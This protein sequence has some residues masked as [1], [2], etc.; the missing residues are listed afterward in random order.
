MSEPKKLIEVAM[1]IKE[2]S[3]ESVRDKSIRRGH[4]STLH[5]WWARR[6]IPVCRAVIFASL[7]PDPLDQNC[8]KQFKE[9]IEIL[10]GAKNNIGDSYKP[11]EDI[12]YTSAIDLMDDNLRNRLMMFIGKFSERYIQA[13]KKGKSVGASETLSEASLV[14][15]ENK[16]NELI[17]G[18]ARKLIWVAHNA[19][20]SQKSATDLL[21][22]FDSTYN[23]IKEAE[24]ALYS[25]TDRH[26]NSEQVNSKN[27]DLQK[28]IDAFQNKMP[29]VFD[30]FAGGGAI[31]LE[32]ARFG[33]KTY[34]ND[35][36]PVAHIIQKASL[37]F[38]QKYGKRISFSNEEFINIYGIER[39]NE[40]PNEWK[41]YSNGSVYRIEIPNRLAFDFE[42]HA[43]NILSI[44]KMKYE[45]LYPKPKEGYETFSY[46]WS[47]VANCSNPS[48][49]AKVP[50]ISN[51]Y[52][53]KP[54]SSKN[55]S[56]FVFLA[57][58]IEGTKI[59]FSIQRGTTNQEPWINRGNVKCPCCSSITENA[60]LKTQFIEGKIT[61]NL[62]A[63]VCNTKTGRDYL[64]PDK[65]QQ[66]IIESIH[67]ESVP[68]GN[69]HPCA[70]GGDTFPWGITQWEQLYNKRQSHVLVGLKNIINEYFDKNYFFD[71]E[72]KKVLI[73]YC[74]I[75]LDKIVLRSTSFGQWHYLQETVEHLFGRQTVSMSFSY[76]ELNPFTY[77]SNG[78]LGQLSSIINYIEEESSIPFISIVNNSVSGEKNQFEK[79]WLDAVITDP[80][81]Y[82]AIAYADVS[83]FF[84]LWLKSVLTE[85]YPSVFVYPQTPKTDEC[86]ALKHHHNDDKNLASLHFENKLKE[87]FCSLEHQTKEIVSIMF[88]HQSTTAWT[89]LCNSILGAKMNITGSWATD[90]EVIGALK[91]GKGYLASSV[92]IAAKPSQKQ[93]YGNYRD[94]KQSI[95]KTVAKEVEELHRLGFRGADLLTACFGQ[96]V[97]E[98]GKYE[99]VE[100]ADGS[101]V[102]VAELLEMARESAFNA[103]LKGF[104]G[105][106]FTKFYIGWLQLNGLIDTDF[107]DA[108]K[109]T[110]V[111][112][113]L[114]VQDLFKDHILIKNG[115]KQHLGSL[116]ERINLN[117]RLGE[118]R[119]NTIIDITHKLMAFYGSNNRNNLLKFI[120]H[121][122]I[123]SDSPVWRVLTS[124][125]ELLPKDMED[126]KLA[127]GLLTNKDQLIR[128]A[129]SSTTPKP[130]QSQ[131][132]FE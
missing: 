59:S 26:I 80:P 71:E 132:T 76:P 57:P 62:L 6:P 35:I 27:V 52:I 96:A 43:N 46:L 67:E 12:P 61:E 109:F 92:T 38:P 112:L 130:E 123:D 31:P 44:A 102:T 1:P 51:F 70:A 119:S 64:I 21:L 4:V 116:K 131:L 24:N 95:E 84:Y 49:K 104:D 11:Y 47:R 107:D 89:T 36:N 126:H 56:N 93:G 37:E 28:A 9:V 113:S 91:T 128:E 25:I 41:V 86:T 78:S 105:D 30:P 54:R 124:L 65:N 106:E 29:K 81:Y 101:E 98:F 97:S 94:V 7:V 87:I 120:E 10:L 19:V 48:C 5:L 68:K 73:T 58:M 75:W 74:A 16:N 100:K 129:K 82:D 103:L 42:T 23:A 13:I 8:P 22:E 17:I 77:S 39:F 66:E 33:C 88:A 118:S 40:I 121:N 50:L 20:N 63:I 111:G 2:I 32:A 127:V 108:A 18:K 69:M 45:K 53:S 114:N 79:K 14:K 125:S 72:Y 99:K 117:S 83:D 115:N 55:D 34:G 60:I 110:K 15:W 85:Y 3:A 90:S 122:S